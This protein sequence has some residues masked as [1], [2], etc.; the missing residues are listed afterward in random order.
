MNKSYNLK[1][2]LYYVNFEVIQYLLTLV[3]YYHS[4]LDLV[5]VGN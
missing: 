2:K 1:A 3:S 5:Y 4:L